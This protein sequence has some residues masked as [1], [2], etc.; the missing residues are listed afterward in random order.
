MFEK[1]FYA[2]CEKSVRVIKGIVGVLLCCM[3]L[4]VVFQVIWRGIL[5]QPTPWTEEISTY[6]VTYIT[7]LGGI[8]VMIRGEHLAIDLVTE[9]VSPRFREWFQVLYGLIYLFV[10][11]YLA[12]Y[13]FQLCANPLIQ[14]Q[15]SI[16]TQIPRVY[17]YVIMP[18]SM[19]LCDLYCIFNLFFI[20]RR[21]LGMKKNGGPACVQSPEPAEK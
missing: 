16:A 11:T 5:R 13:G 10:C 6:L 19:V 21:L 18:V 8:A 7:F 4:V 3:L 1:K 9:H 15:L 12:V 14:K 17:I 20:V 2:L